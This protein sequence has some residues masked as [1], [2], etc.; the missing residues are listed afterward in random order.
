MGNTTC[1]KWCESWQSQGIFMPT[2][3]DIAF[4]N[5][6]FGTGDRVGVTGAIE[7]GKDAKYFLK[8]AGRSSTG[9][10]QA[11]INSSLQHG[12]KQGT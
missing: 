5:R 10:S 6:Y 7:V 12:A 4:P 8:G 9:G 1:V 11:S 2:L 3:L